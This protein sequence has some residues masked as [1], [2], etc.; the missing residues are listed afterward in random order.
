[1]PY[2]LSKEEMNIMIEKYQLIPNDI[3]IQ[4]VKY[5]VKKW[6]YDIDGRRDFKH[7]LNIELKKYQLK[8]KLIINKL[9]EIKQN[10]IILLLKKQLLIKKYEEIQTSERINYMISKELY[11]KYH[12]ECHNNY[13]LKSSIK[14]GIWLKN[15]R[16]KNENNLIKLNNTINN[17]SILNIKLQKLNNA[18]IPL[19]ELTSIINNITNTNILPNYNTLELKKSF[20]QLKKETAKK[21]LVGD[22]KGISNYSN[23]ITTIDFNKHLNTVLIPFYNKL[24]QNIKQ[25]TDQAKNKHDELLK[26]IT[27]TI[28]TDKIDKTNNK[29]EKTNK[30]EALNNNNEKN[31]NSKFYYNSNEAINHAIELETKINDKK[32]EEFKKWL[33]IKQIE[34]QKLLQLEVCLLSIP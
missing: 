20:I 4:E 13:N 16:L 8:H 33:K 28:E 29:I 3:L 23:L 31:N 14:W 10:E 11:W 32:N 27:T 22:S 21:S 24:P 26:T 17:N 6:L 30:I 2:S 25:L 12:T 19:N 9:N 18:V 5:R 7:Q 1:M 34:K 15:Y